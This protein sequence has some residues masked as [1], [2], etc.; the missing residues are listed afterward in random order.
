MKNLNKSKLNLTSQQEQALV[1][2]KN[3]LK[4][5]YE[6][7]K[8]LIFGS[9]A[10]HEANQESDLDFLVLTKKS[11]SHKQKHDIYGITTEINLAYGT[12]ISV[13]V[14]EKNSWEKGLYSVLAIKEEVERDGV[15]F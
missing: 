2:L 3:K 12:N 9:V 8:S 4:N 10:R 11:I 5:K 14:I 6:I 13:L 7:E 15:V 1:E